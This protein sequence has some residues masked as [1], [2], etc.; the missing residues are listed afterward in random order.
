MPLCAPE[1]D[2]VTVEAVIEGVA[3]RRHL[4]LGEDQEALIDSLFQLWVPPWP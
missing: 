4:T 1:A 3:L 2:R